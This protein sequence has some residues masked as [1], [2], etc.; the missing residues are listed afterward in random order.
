MSA[1]GHAGSVKPGESGQMPTP[2]TKNPKIVRLEFP[3][4]LSYKTNQ[5]WVVTEDQ[6]EIRLVDVQDSRCPKGV[7]CVWA[8]SVKVVLAVA[9]PG[10]S[11]TEVSFELGNGIEKSL[12][13]IGTHRLWFKSVQPYPEKAAEQILLSDY[14]VELEYTNKAID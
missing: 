10:K 6:I 12:D 5:D 4:T 1:C 13:K 8:G 3:F 11:V 9:A 14:V 2:E 7:T